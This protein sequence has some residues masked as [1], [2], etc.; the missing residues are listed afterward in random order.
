MGFFLLLFLFTALPLIEVTLLF[1]IGHVIGGANTIA[2]VLVTGFVGASLARWQGLEVLAQLRGDL[3]QGRPD[4]TLLEGVFVLLA[5][6]VLITPGVLTDAFG[7]LLLIPPIRRALADHI[8]RNATGRVHVFHTQDPFAP[9]SYEPNAEVKTID[10]TV[11]DPSE[12]D[13]PEPERQSPPPPA[14]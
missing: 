8:L 7:L 2:L 10:A 5:G 1:R 4:R 6:A 13:A 3:A 14:S 12:T 9:P 11:S